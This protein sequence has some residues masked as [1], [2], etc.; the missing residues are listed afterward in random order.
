VNGKSSSEHNKNIRPN[1]TRAIETIAVTATREEAPLNQL[2]G[3][4]AVIDQQ[5]LKLIAPTHIQQ[6]MARVPGANVARGNG[7]EYLPALRSP[8]LTGAG[9]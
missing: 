1:I 3:N 9:G 8:V 7:Q 4:T 2:A 6:V 5:T